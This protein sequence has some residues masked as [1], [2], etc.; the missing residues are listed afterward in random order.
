MVYSQVVKDYNEIQTIKV[1]LLLY[2][3]FQVIYRRVL[4]GISSNSPEESHELL[5]CGLL[6]EDFL[7]LRTTELYE[8]CTSTAITDVVDIQPSGTYE[9]AF[10]NSAIQTNTEKNNFSRTFEL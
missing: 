4:S 5:N 8:P 3:A 10:D 1:N 6:V 7:R 2:R 9:F